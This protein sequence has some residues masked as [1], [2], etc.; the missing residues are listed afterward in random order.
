[1]KKAYLSAALS[2]LCLATLGNCSTTAAELHPDVLPIASHSSISH[3]SIPPSPASAVSLVPTVGVTTERQSLPVL[4]AILGQWTVNSGR[5]YASFNS[6]QSDRAGQ[7]DP[8][9]Q[10]LVSGQTARMQAPIKWLNVMTLKL[11]A[12]RHVLTEFLDMAGH[13]LSSEW[14]YKSEWIYKKDQMQP[15]N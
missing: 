6:S 14:V 3:S 15:R 1:M 9:A 8:A 10:T 11:T 4:Q 5:I 12:N 7:V 2:A 13:N